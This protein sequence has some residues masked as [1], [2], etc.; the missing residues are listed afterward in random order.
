MPLDLFDKINK[1]LKPYTNELAYHVVGDPLVLTNLDKYLDISFNHK[2]K[3]NITTAASNLNK[4]QYET[5]I[6]QSIRQVNFSINSFNANDFKKNIDEY[7]TPIFD[8]CQ[9]ALD[10]KR[11]YFINL[12]IWNLDES[13][14]AKEFNQKVFDKANKY[15]NSQINCDE[16]YK[17]KPKNIRVAR[18]IFFNF[19]DYFQWPSLENDFVS[20]TGFCYGLNSHFGILANG[21]VIPCCL[22]KDAIINL[23]NVNDNSLHEILD[24]KRV[25]NIQNGFK[26]NDVVEELCKKCSFRVRFD[27]K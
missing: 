2:L 8:F 17:N 1:E 27:K 12:R 25:S 4:N 9:Y 10:N 23:G 26:N 16:I 22:D 6:H 11:D 3:V 19:D 20:D 24:S 14:S 5:L 21:D 15:F 7:L 13:K 18:K